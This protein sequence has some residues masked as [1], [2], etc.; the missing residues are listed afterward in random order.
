M[1][2]IY[3]K[4]EGTRDPLYGKFE[5]PIKAIIQDEANHREE[6]K[7]IL[8]ALYNVEKSHPLQ[9]PLCPRSV[10]IRS[11]IRAKANAPQI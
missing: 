4:L 10:L 5:K 7:T 9:K 2:I 8:K 6:D 3:S 1:G 11:S